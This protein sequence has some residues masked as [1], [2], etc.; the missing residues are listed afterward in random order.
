MY[1]FLA[2]SIFHILYLFIF[3]Y[4]KSLLNAKTAVLNYQHNYSNTLSRWICHLHYIYCTATKQTLV[5]PLISVFYCIN[6][7]CQTTF[8]TFMCKTN[9]QNNFKL[10]TRTILYP[11]TRW[12]SLMRLVTSVP[13]I[14]IIQGLSS[15]SSSQ[16]IYDPT[17]RGT[18]DL[19]RVRPQGGLSLVA[20]SV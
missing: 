18:K 4:I 8:Y 12:E 13:H 16:D 14:C 11:D 3:Y 5:M 20:Q 7:I 17:D 6:C 10:N 1:I 9:R 15:L 2:F 19:S